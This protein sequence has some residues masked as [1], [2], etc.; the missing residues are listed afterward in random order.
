MA[1]GVLHLK[2]QGAWAEVYVDGHSLGRVPP[3]NSHLL[4]P[5]E[6]ALE[7]RNP[8][9][10]PYRQTVRIT[11]NATHTVAVDFKALAR[12]SATPAPP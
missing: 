5:G 9:F 4:P 2:V 12:V 7:L 10:E 8:A 6:H 1:S 3:Q 11:A